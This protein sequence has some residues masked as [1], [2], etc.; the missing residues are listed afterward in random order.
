MKPTPN[1]QDSRKNL[2]ETRKKTKNP[3]KTRPNNTPQDPLGSQ[4]GI[5]LPIIVSHILNLIKMMIVQSVFGADNFYRFRKLIKPQGT[6]SESVSHELELILQ[7]D[8]YVIQVVYSRVYF[9]LVVVYVFQRV[10]TVPIANIT[11]ID[12]NKTII[13]FCGKKNKI[14]LEIHEYDTLWY[15]RVYKFIYIEKLKWKYTSK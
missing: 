9:M 7:L 12:L 11:R 2:D 1:G 5:N 6:Y 15:S 14:P 8:L 4:E 10:I 3:R 13:G